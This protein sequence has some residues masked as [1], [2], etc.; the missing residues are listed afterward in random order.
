MDWEIR[1]EQAGW[2]DIDLYVDSYKCE[3]SCVCTLSQSK[4]PIFGT[5][6]KFTRT[7]KPDFVL[8]RNTVRRIDGDFRKI[9]YGLNT[10]CIESYNS[11][12]SI[13]LS[14]ERPVMFGALNKLK[15]KFGKD[16][17]GKYKFPLIDQYVFC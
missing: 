9:M 2:E 16:K 13:I 5:N 15:K 10:A 11:F 12:E 7:F 6:Q 14:N 17:D 3:N 1:V 4:E 8:V